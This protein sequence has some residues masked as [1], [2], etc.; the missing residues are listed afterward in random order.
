M[1]KLH[2][3][4]GLVGLAMIGFFTTSLF[5]DV[6][7]LFSTFSEFNAASLVLLVSLTLAIGVA[8]FALQ[9][10][11]FESFRSRLM[12]RMPGFPA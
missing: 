7:A 11:K 1:R 12:A 5:I 2:S 8:L 10:T 3:I 4:L 6:G 9:K